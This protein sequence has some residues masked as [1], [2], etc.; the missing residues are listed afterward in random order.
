MAGL[1][2]RCSYFQISSW[3]LVVCTKLAKL[4]NWHDLRHE[5]E[6][7]NETLSE[8]LIRPVKEIRNDLM[9][10]DIY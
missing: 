5:I 7:R 2:S 1:H 4:I 9:Q 6:T 10:T 8:I 3:M